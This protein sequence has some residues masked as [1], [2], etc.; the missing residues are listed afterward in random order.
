MYL[1]SFTF[2]KIFHYLHEFPIDL[3]LHIQRLHIIN[4]QI[5]NKRFGRQ[6]YG[7]SLRFG[8]VRNSRGIS[9][10]RGISVCGVKIVIAGCG[11][12]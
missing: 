1:F 7:L 3:P 2:K 6:F 8:Q 5:L 12:D 11:A 10:F 4:G 9:R